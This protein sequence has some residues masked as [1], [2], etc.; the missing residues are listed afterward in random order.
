MISFFSIFPLYCTFGLCMSS[1]IML[2]LSMMLLC[3]WSRFWPA[4]IRMLSPC[5]WFWRFFFFPLEINHFCWNSYLANLTLLGLSVLSWYS[6]PLN[7]SAFLALGS[8]FQV[9]CLYSSAYDW[10]VIWNDGVSKINYFFRGSSKVF[11][12][13]TYL[14]P[15]YRCSTGSTD[16]IFWIWY[17]LWFDVV[18]LCVL[19][20]DQI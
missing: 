11:L 15:S 6:C 9:R 16:F 1:F 20:A 4:S 18:L 3:C 13:P 12:L 17:N 8:P 19:L 2:R 5:L 7:P 14:A 10:N